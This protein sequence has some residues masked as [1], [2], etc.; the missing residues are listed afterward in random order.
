MA[1]SQSFAEKCFLPTYDLSKIYPSP[2]VL[3]SH[4]KVMPGGRWGPGGAGGAAPI[5]RR[6]RRQKP[7]AVIIT[8]DEWCEWTDKSIANPGCVFKIF[9]HPA[10]HRRYPARRLF[11]EVRLPS[12]P[13]QVG[14]PPSLNSG[15][16]LFSPREVKWLPIALGLPSSLCHQRPLAAPWLQPQVPPAQ[17]GPGPQPKPSLAAAPPPCR[18]R[19]GRGGGPPAFGRDFQ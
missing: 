15:S 1:T 11:F 4:Q 9:Y 10:V 14:T 13:G 6:W 17:R 19:R 5:G 3:K 12:R 18:G 7:I 8:G 2:R 16:P